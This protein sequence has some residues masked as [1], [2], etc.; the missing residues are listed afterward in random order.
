MACGEKSR[1]MQA[2]YDVTIRRRIN[3]G[4]QSCSTIRSCRMSQCYTH[5]ALPTRLTSAL[6]V[7]DQLTS[8]ALDSSADASRPQTFLV[9]AKWWTA[10]PYL[11]TYT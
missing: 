11:E 10:N 5:S 7:L 4:M 1:H 2:K 3:Q 8:L 9:G 6:P